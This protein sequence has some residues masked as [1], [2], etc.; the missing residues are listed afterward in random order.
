MTYAYSER[1]M[2][3]VLSSAMPAGVAS[4]ACAHLSVS[5]G[6]RLGHADMGATSMSSDG[7]AYPAILKYAIVTLAASP[8]KTNTIARL[9][10]ADTDVLFARFTEDMLNTESDNDLRVAM[11]CKSFAQMAHLGVGLYG[12]AERI[13]ALTRGLSLWGRSVTP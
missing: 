10:Q 4:N 7:V 11:G 6:H 12:S 8:A 3:I 1:K 2:A 9:A 13:K 5:L